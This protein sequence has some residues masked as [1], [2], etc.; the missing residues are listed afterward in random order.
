V[1]K[2][3]PRFARRPR[4][5]GETWSQPALR[6]AQAMGLITGGLALSVPL[7]LA[8]KVMLG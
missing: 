2:P 6:L 4:R 7:I 8:W 1:N 5:P 3:L